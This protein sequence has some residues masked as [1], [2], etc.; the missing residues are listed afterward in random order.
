MNRQIV[1][2]PPRQNPHPTFH[3]VVEPS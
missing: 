1:P 2:P 3:P